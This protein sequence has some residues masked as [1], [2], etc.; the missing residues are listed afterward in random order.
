[1]ILARSALVWLARL[2]VLSAC[3][4]AIGLTLAYSFGTEQTWLLEL[5]RYAPFPAYLLPSLLA[6]G[7][8]FVLLGWGWR[9]TAVA[10]IVLMLTRVMGLSLGLDRIEPSTD[11]AIQARTLR[12]MTYNI[13]SY[14]AAWR[15]DGFK[16][17]AG[18]IE[19]HQ[20][21]LIVMQDAT[22]IG[23]PGRLLDMLRQSRPQL[24]HVYT[25]DQYAVVSRYPVRDC[26]PYDMSAGGTIRREYVRCVVRIDGTDVDLVV[27]HFITPR[28]GLNAV[29]SDK[30]SGLDD[31]RENYTTR[32]AQ[33]H[34]VQSDLS[35]RTE[36][37][38]LLVAGDLNA[39]EESPVV[40]GLLALGLRDAY[41]Q[42]GRGYGYT[43]GH[44]L[45]PGVS[46]L[47]I[48]HI[49]V[50]EE[51]GVLRCVTG[52]RGASEHRPVVADL[53]LAPDRT[54]DKP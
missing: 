12:F 47:R 29:R 17:L 1:M 32:L 4:C 5:L 31:W 23:M 14:R 20:P 28:E 39:S 38:P 54:A 10:A 24:Q 36:R 41:S 49:L 11:S 7:L 27:I 51:F 52:W 44:A 50:S 34:Q 26:K 46:F 22:H 3:A 42:A 9:I 6:L 19:S 21:D 2:G 33:S 40:Q 30:G 35:L 25:Y 13:K 15:W 45:K 18:E 16:E 48:D 37:R 8:S 53:V 43:I